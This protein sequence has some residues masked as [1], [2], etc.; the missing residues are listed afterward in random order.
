M[1]AKID[2]LEGETSMILSSHDGVDDLYWVD[3]ESPDGT[4]VFEASTIWDDPNSLTNG[5]FA[6]PHPTLNWP[7][8]S[9]SEAL[10][11]G[12]WKARTRSAAAR[13]DITVE[14]LLDSDPDFETGA[15]DIRVFLAG[16][17]A[18]D[19]EVVDAVAAAMSGWE[20]LYAQVGI[21]VTH[22]TV[23]YPTEPTLAPPG[24]DETGTFDAIKA[25]VPP[26]TIP[27]VIVDD[28]D[29]SAEVYGIAGDI[30]GP[31]AVANR[32]AVLVSAL[33]SAGPDGTFSDDDVD[34]LAETMAHETL[35]FTGVFHP[36]EITWDHWDSLDGTAECESQGTCI[37]QLGD[38]LMFPFP[39][40][41]NL[42]C[43][44][45]DQLA[46]EQGR[47]A[48]RYTGVR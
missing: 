45:Q 42:G 13:T 11:P 9:G 1:T 16:T 32:S 30:P 20:D 47:A 46:K 44:P 10:T 12:R 3:L 23:D 35:H 48:N 2:V 29:F 25:S 14:V 34:L 17:T 31:L 18:E 38:N 33:Y 41:T 5:A 40:C 8:H 28:V 4:L 24:F 27:V 7:I 26:A 43:Q 6:S 19:P 36:V 37:A 39:I 21:A 15:L 22:E